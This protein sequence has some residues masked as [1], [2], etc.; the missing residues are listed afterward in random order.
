[1]A[2]MSVGSME[3]AFIATP[4]AA[5]NVVVPTTFPLISNLIESI[6]SDETLRPAF[7]MSRLAV[8]SF[9]TIS[10]AALNPL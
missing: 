9:P 1:M 6:A 8:T 4:P 3:E 5:V 10:W 2:P 7:V